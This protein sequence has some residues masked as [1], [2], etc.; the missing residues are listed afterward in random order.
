MTIDGTANE[1]HP[2]D[3]GQRHWW[4]H[5]GD[6]MLKQ[7]DCGL[8][9]EQDQDDRDTRWQVSEAGASHTILHLVE[10]VCWVGKAAGAIGWTE[11]NT[12]VD[13]EL[14]SRDATVQV[15]FCGRFL[16]ILPHPDDQ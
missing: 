12:L 2:P 9:Q 6:D 10:S 13:T 16:H 8:D 15:A 3:E 14:L 5:K 1:K 7:C 11:R 4:C